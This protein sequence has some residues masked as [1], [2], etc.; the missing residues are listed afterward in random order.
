M[1]S[2]LKDIF[3]EKL[4]DDD[5]IDNPLF[6][7]DVPVFGVSKT[8]SFLP[9][10]FAFY[11]QL[12]VLVVLQSAFNAILGYFVYKFLVERSSTTKT[13]DNGAM[14][15]LTPHL[16]AYGVAIPLV[17]ME[18]IYMME[19][20]D[21]KNVGLGMA[22]LATP[23]NLSLR[24]AEA[25]YGFVPIPMKENLFNY[26][27]YF[28]CFFG[29]DFDTVTKTPKRISSNFISK[30]LKAIGREYVLMLFL[31]SILHH[32]DYEFFDTKH[33][34]YG[35]EHSFHDLFSWQHLL[36]NYLVA[37]LLSISL[38]QS[39]MGVC[40]LYNFFYGFETYEVVQNP[41]LKSKSVSEF[42]GKRWN[43]S[44]H[45]GLKNGVYKPT[46][47]YTSSK[48]LGAV[49]TFA[50]SGIIHEYVNF[51]LFY[52]NGSGQFSSGWNQV[53]FFGWN[54]ILLALEYC[55]GHWAIF[56]WMSRNLPQFVI[57]ALVLTCALPLAHL[58]TGD[59]IQHG[60]FDA[61]YIV[62]FVVEC[63]DS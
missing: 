35:T 1:S 36:N 12:V 25:L 48:I 4:I 19:Y 2:L 46:L 18:P 49:V 47:Q 57:T 40:I 53:I 20:L 3:A 61:V 6:T 41:M 5:R 51:V 52:R 30:R 26:I 17:A 23:I 7:F 13:K 58:F 50:V 44:V 38:S 11:Y 16:F 39:S 9:P 54:G 33:H 29:I 22:F 63:R 42:W 31:I 32:Y 28:S 34:A 37:I 62:E 21:I 55:I 24:I 45:K 10:K 27:I 59:Y 14:T 15:A 8:C 56:K 43:Q 60:W